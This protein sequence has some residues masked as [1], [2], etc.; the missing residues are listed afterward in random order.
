MTGFNRHVRRRTIGRYRISITGAIPSPSGKRLVVVLKGDEHG[1]LIAIRQERSKQW[2]E[3]DVPGLYL[4][5]LLAKAR[6]EK[7]AKKKARSLR[8]G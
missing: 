7:A 8:S 1:D 4:R 3:F 6:Q 5:G 2:V